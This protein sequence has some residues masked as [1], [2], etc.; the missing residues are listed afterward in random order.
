MHCASPKLRLALESKGWSFRERTEANQQ[1]MRDS[2]Q[3]LVGLTRGVVQMVTGRGVRE[4]IGQQPLAGTQA[5]L[6]MHVV[7]WRYGRQ[8]IALQRQ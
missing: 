4:V 6:R 5:P 1:R 2:Y 8:I 7:P 3:K